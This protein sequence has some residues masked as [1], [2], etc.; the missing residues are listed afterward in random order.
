MT[1]K[2]VLPSENICS[3]GAVLKRGCVLELPG[4]SL[5]PWGLDATAQRVWL[6]WSGHSWDITLPHPPG[7]SNTLQRLRTI[8]LKQFLDVGTTILGLITLCWDGLPVYHSMFSSIR[9]F[10]PLDTVFP[11][12][13]SPSSVRQPRCLQTLPNVEVDGWA[14][15][16][17]SPGWESLL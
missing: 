4:D 15:C 12:C 6:T 3:K 16:K 10:Y 8:D 5:E 7:D 9:G 13:H 17:F 2:L 11:P 1:P 14:G